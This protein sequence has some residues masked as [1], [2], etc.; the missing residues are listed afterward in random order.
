MLQHRCRA[1]PPSG[2]RQHAGDYLTAHPA[3]LRSY[4]GRR[5]LRSAQPAVND[6]QLADYVPTPRLLELIG[7][8]TV[9]A[10]AICYP[11]SLSTIFPNPV[12]T[13]VA[14]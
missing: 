8:G 13:S 4:P 12:Q 7:D 14:G 2:C 3:P 9:D 6:R 11:L 10:T 5:L 1:H